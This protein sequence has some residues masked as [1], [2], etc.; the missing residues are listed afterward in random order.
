MNKV[1]HFGCRGAMGDRSGKK[2]KDRKQ[3]VLR[4]SE[5]F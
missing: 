1:D 4:N 2:V 5:R 3:R